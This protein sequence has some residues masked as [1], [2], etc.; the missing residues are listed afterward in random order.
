MLLFSFMKM[1][2]IIYKHFILIIVKVALN[3]LVLSIASQRKARHSRDR[4]GSHC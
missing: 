4:E 1:L 2:N 3:D